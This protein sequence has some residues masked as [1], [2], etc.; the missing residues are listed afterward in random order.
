MIKWSFVLISIWNLRN[1]IQNYL[2]KHYRAWVRLVV[3]FLRITAYQQ[4]STTKWSS[5][6]FQIQVDRITQSLLKLTRK[7]CWEYTNYLD[8]KFELFFGNSV[9]ITQELNALI[10]KFSEH[11]HDAWA[12]RKLDNGWQFGD[13]YNW[14]ERIHPR[15]K[16]YHM[17]TDYVSSYFNS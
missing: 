17:L 2:E 8:F 10:Q 12:G 13:Q 15:L 11:Y 6:Q 7:Y 3:L 5:L 9:Q 14:N 4:A 1:M 16:P